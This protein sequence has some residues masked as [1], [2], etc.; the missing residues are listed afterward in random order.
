MSLQIVLSKRFKKDLK[1]AKRRG[2]DLNLLNKIVDKLA[3]GEKLDEK[4]RDHEQF[5]DLFG[6]RECHIKPDWMLVYR[7]DGCNLVLFLNRTGSHADLF[8]M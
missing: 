7:I 3:N 2:L 1:L 4:Y 5:G 6:F 8:S